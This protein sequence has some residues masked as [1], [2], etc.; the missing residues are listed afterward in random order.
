VAESEIKKAL[1]DDVLD[2]NHPDDVE[3]LTLEEFRRLYFK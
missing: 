2:R 3:S 1:M